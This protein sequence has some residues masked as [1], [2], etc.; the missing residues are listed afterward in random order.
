MT[1]P[2]LHHYPVS[3]FAE[4]VRAM[5]GFKDLAWKSVQIP[6]VMPKPD[7][8]ALTGGYR[9]TPILQLGADVYCDTA[10]IA[11]VLERLEPSPSL[12]PQGDTVA[13]RA[14]EHFADSV[15]FNIVI[16]VAF[17][18]GGGMIRLYYPDA[19]PEFLANFGKDR[20][21]IRQGG[22]LR[23]GP[24][25][26]CKA[27]TQGLLTKVEAQLQAPFL[28]GAQPCAADFSLYHVLWPLWKVADTQPM[29]APYPKARN[30][31]ER[32]VAMG[33]GT[34]TE[35][36]SGEA[37]Q[38]AK[39]SRPEPVEGAVALETDGIALGQQATVMPVDSGFEPT[40]GELINASADEIV[41]RRSDPRAG[42]V[43]VHFPRFGF[44]LNK[45]A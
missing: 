32:I 17:Q 18:P 2:V 45:P 43:H 44:Q 7:V 38:I 28:F 35:I 16:P 4:K 22:T 1:E 24:L 23:R 29:L 3:P 33:H 12:F 40:T 27:N 26:E 9:K 21:A 10:L 36:T 11:R 31:I 39:S 37:L 6:L 15:M 25:H 30:F 8:V 19:T 14:M 20:A 41:L 34:T 42:T 13:V 5:L